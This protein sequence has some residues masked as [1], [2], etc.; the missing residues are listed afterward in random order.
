[1]TTTE[2]VLSRVELR[3]QTF[4]REFHHKNKEAKRA[5]MLTFHSE[6][7]NVMRFSDG[8]KLRDNTSVPCWIDKDN[9]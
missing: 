2:S 1:M 7:I 5:E 8:L 6:I 3:M 4:L 9:V